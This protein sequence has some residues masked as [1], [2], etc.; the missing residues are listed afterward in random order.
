MLRIR[1]HALVLGGR[2]GILVL[3]PTGPGDQILQAALASDRGE[4]ELLAKIAAGED[5]Q[6]LLPG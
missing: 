2:E 5:L 1:L 6:G 3:P 4:P